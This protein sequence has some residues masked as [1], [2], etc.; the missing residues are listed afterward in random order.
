[1]CYG[2]YAVSAAK[3]LF[4][5]HHVTFTRVLVIMRLLYF[6]CYV[7]LIIYQAVLFSEMSIQATQQTDIINAD[8]TKL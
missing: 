4:Y 8:T 1:M 6:L 2:C 7:L 5:L 3:K